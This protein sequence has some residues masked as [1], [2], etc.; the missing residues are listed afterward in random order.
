[1]DIQIAEEQGAVILNV[2]GRLDAVS[3]AEFDRQCGVCADKKP[4]RLLLDFAGLDYISSAGLRSLLSLAKK[5]KN[6]GGK[7][8]VCGLK[9]VVR[10]VVELSGF[11]QFLP[12][13]DDRPSALQKMA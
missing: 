7:L 11:D 10:E 4:A 6:S 3:A 13:F 2:A 8:G 12:I 9:G 5:M 1:M